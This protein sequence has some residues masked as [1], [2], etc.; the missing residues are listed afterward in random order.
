M[1]VLDNTAAA[2][3][4][5]FD[6]DAQK[7]LNTTATELQSQQHGHNLEI[8][9]KLQNLCNRTLVFEIKLTN[10]NLKEGS[11][12]YTVTKDLCPKQYLGD[13]TTLETNQTGKDSHQ[14]HFSFLIQKLN[15]IHFAV[16]LFQNYIIK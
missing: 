3:L 7:L 9:S 6:Q 2:T 13:P 16:F 1:K 8:P 10:H 12:N 4:T 15:K 5:I 14:I 11:H